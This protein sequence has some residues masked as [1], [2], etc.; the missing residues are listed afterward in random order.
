[1]SP[2]IVDMHLTV[3]T[4]SKGIWTIES[5]VE[6]LH[7]ALQDVKT[8]LSALPLVVPDEYFETY[9]ALPVPGAI[10]QYG[11]SYKYTAKFTSSVS[12]DVNNDEKSYVAPPRN[13]WN[14]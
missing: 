14:R 5:T 9:S 8:S 6:D 7:K 11:N 1:M 2:F 3:Y 13:A 4:D 12:N 10:P